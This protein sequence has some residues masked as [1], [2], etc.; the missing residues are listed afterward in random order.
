MTEPEQALEQARAA[1]ASMRATG[2]YEEDTRRAQ[3]PVGAV[4][5]AQLSEWAAL[6]PDVRAVRSTRRYGAPLTAFKRVLVRLLS[7]YHA[8]LIS[9]QTRFNVKVLEEVEQLER[10]LEALER[11]SGDGQRQ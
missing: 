11:R 1:A 6:D 7:Q 9:Q 3:P 2:A 10:R 4:T 5:R 8:D